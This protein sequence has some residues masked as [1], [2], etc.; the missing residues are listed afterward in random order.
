MASAILLLDATVVYIGLP[1]IGADLGASFDELQWTIDAYT[2]TLAVALLPAGALAD[3]AGRRRVFVAGLALFA[4]A[5]AACALAWSPLALVLARAVQG[6]GAAA[7]FSASLAL[8]ATAYEGAAR[9]RALAVWGAIGGAALAAGPAVGGLVTDGPG[10]RWLFAV[11]LPIAAATIVAAQRRVPEW[12]DPAAPPPDRLGAV[13]SAGALGLLVA[14][15]LRGEPDGWT[16]PGVLGAYAAGVVLLA[17]FVAAELRSRAP[18]LDVRLFRRPAFAGTAGFAFFQSVAIYPVF[19][20]VAIDLQG[21]QGLTPLEAGL[22]V[23]PI[24]LALFV[25]APFAGRLTAR[26]PL[27]RLLVAGLA[28]VAA[29]LVA[30]RA[31]GPEDGYLAELPAYLLIGAGSGILSP[32][33][34]AAMIATLPPERAGLASGMGNAFRQA[35]IAVGIAVIGAVL[36]VT[37]GG[38]REVDAALAGRAGVEASAAAAIRFDAG[39]DDALLGCLLAAVAGAAAAAFVR[40]RID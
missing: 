21:I 32:S 18:M 12:R 31:V 15:T 2:L 26:L 10:W 13:L 1:T 34:A 33:F 30:L 3:R 23:L 29:G 5:S 36:H 8:L 14:A 20:L 9:A 37:A 22:R 35:G 38:D 4:L 28:V 11:N 25:V 16:S 7:T 6:V 17:G 27:N 24:T 39:L 19:L 40:V